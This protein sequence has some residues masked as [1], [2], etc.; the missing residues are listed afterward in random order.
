MKIAIIGAGFTGLTAAYQLSKLGHQVTVFE[1]ME[2]PGGLAAGFKDTAWNWPLE[3][4][5]HHLFTS[6]TAILN[7][8]IQVGHKIIFKRPKT[9]TFYN[10]KISQLDSPLSLLNFT[11]LPLLDRIRTGLGLAFLKF[12]PIW[13]P[14]EWFTAK[15]F[16]LTIMGKN[17]WQVLW[18]PLFKG[19]FG[20]YTPRISAAWF[21]SRIFKRSA[22]LG[23]PEG[24]FASLAKSIEAKANAF[25]SKFIYST[26]IESIT[27][28]L[29]ISF[30]K[31]TQ[32]YDQVICTL[33]VHQ[34]QKICPAALP[35]TD[36]LLGLGAIN[37]VIAL[38]TPFF[39][40]K[41]YW[42]NAND[43]TLPFL[44]VVEHT[45]FIDGSHYGG[46]HLIYVGNYLDPAHPYFELS[47]KQL[48]A[49]FMPGLQII[50]PNFSIK[51]VRKMWAF[52][53]KFAQPVVTTHYSAK[54]P[55]HTTNVPNLYLANI[56]QVYPWDRGTN[57]AV[58]LGEKV[59]RLCITK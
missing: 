1:Q 21:W 3:H 48:L 52:K 38:K 47:E 50:N 11:E 28:D 56:Q 29:K 10:N 7:L 39:A 34:L 12:N 32:K 13:R 53:A 54:I 22:S 45:N 25:G 55:P 5:Y 18:E 59:A 14:F 46:D 17:S 43:R 2:Q 24:G 20:E 40:D 57:Y 51:N 35:K 15:G 9:A 8:A 6:D 42:L 36:K 16:I 30:G 31:T 26:T 41:T 37:L 27:E 49:E 4:H 44:A 23:Y 58:E 33:P 19:K